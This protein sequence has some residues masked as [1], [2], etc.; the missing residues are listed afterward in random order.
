MATPCAPELEHRLHVLSEKRRLNRNLVGMV[1]F[2]KLDGT[3]KNHFEFGVMVVVFGEDQFVELEEF[4]LF[5]D[6]ADEPETHDGGAG[7]DAEDDAFLG[8]GVLL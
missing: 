7:I 5:I 2:D 6:H 3:L 8:H 1:R 4:H